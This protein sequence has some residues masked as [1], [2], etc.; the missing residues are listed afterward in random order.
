M[1]LTVEATVDLDGLSLA[2][3]FVAASG[4][5]VGLAGGMG[6]GKS[7]ALRLVAGL[8]AASTGT[9]R[10][11]DT[12]WDQPE[13]GVFVPVAGRPVGFLS[14]RPALVDDQ[15]T[16]NQVGG[17]IGLLGELGLADSVIERDGWT[18]SRGETQ[19]VALAAAVGPDPTVLLLDDPFAAL[20]SVTGRLVRHWLRG[21]LAERTG[22]TLIAAA[23]PADLGPLATRIVTVGG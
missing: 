3:G 23:D 17:H 4:E 7:T 8:V 21:R 1:T 5:V 9:V 19:R 15:P 18:L 16:R 13:A 20:D 11:G 22:V 10:F 6:A 14:P 12:V 2:F